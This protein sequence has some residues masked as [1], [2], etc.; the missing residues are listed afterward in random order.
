[1]NLPANTSDR[2][3]WIDAA[4]GIGII[5]V[6]LGHIWLIGPGQKIINSFHMPLFFFLSGYV[7]HF[8]RYRDFKQFL[9]SKGTRILAPYFWFSLITYFY[10][11]LVERWVSR[12][13]ISPFTTFVNIFRCQGADRYLPH[14]PALWF[15]PCLFVVEVLFY[16]LAKNRN[17]R[18]ILGLLLVISVMSYIIT[19]LCPRNLP[20]G[21]NVALTGIVFYGMGFVLRRGDVWLNSS[22]RVLPLIFGSTA[23]L[24]LFLALENTFVIMAACIFGD[25]FYFY[26]AAFLNITG[27]IAIS[28]LLRKTRWLVYLGRNSLTIFALHFP[29]KRLVVGF[30]C[31]LFQ[32]PLEEIKASFLLSS[33]DALL[34]ILLL[35]PFIHLVRTQFPFILGQSR[36]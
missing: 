8:E 11:L 12:N 34:T 36:G 18:N 33:I 7:F 16:C 25:Y 4:K 17:R 1:M 14:N 26:S 22:Q 29:I 15:L 35:L 30:N 10:W 20:W 19:S 21:M 2:V 3:E 6:V 32:L 9:G 5:L 23:A 31:L 27:I 28:V 24:G 13:A